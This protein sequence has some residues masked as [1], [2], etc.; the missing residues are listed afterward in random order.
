MKAA[1]HKRQELFLKAIQATKGS[2]DDNLLPEP[3]SDAEFREIMITY[4]LGE[5][6]HV[7]S[8]MTQQ[9]VNSEAAYEIID[10]YLGN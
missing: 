3:M 9:Q 5:D 4:F 8:S 10:R 2:K 6:W 1:K 7:A